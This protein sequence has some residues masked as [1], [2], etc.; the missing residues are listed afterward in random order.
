MR[1]K[2][3]LTKNDFVKF[4]TI[5]AKEK[6]QGGYDAATWAKIR[7][8]H[9]GYEIGNEILVITSYSIHYTKL[10]DV[11]K[12]PY[13]LLI[14]KFHGGDSRLNNEFSPADRGQPDSHNSR[15]R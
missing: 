15:Y 9:F 3:G 11:G 4:N 8:A 13:P 2:F 7:E 6:P 14:K 1:N 5:I 12:C 10:Y